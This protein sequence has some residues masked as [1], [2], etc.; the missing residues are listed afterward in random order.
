VVELS[1]P[2]QQLAAE[3]LR[4]AQSQEVER[5]QQRALLA[6]LSA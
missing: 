5:A 6:P 2:V 3:Q 4:E 1:Q